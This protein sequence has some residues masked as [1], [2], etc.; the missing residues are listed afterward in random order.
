VPAG[1]DVAAESAL[2]A[3]QR[4]SMTHPRTTARSLADLVAAG[5]L[6]SSALDD[7]ALAR[8]AR[9]YAIAVT[10]GMLDLMAGTPAD[11]P[12]ARQF[13]PTADEGTTTPAELAD[14]IGDHAHAP[15][16]GIVHR[17]PDRVLLKPLHACPVYCRFCFRREQ[18]GPG[19][20]ALDDAALDAALDYVAG[21]P[22][23]WEVV[24]TGGDPF[25]LSPRRI[26]RIVAALDALPHVA[27]VRFHTRVPLVDPGRVDSALVAALRAARAA[28]YVG[29]HCNHARELTPAARG[30][31]ARLADGGLPLLSQSVLLRGVNDSVEALEAL[32]RGLVAA[33]VR[34]YYL[35][36]PD[37]ARGTSHFR[38]PIEEGQALV[39]A[40]R[41]RLSGLCQPTY[42]LDLPGG[43]GKSPIGPGYIDGTDGDGGHRIRDYRGTVHT[44]AAD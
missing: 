25:M 43:H 22:A 26:A 33:R 14:P 29:V 12:I 1:L 40:L 10:P 7:P 2:K 36:H 28:V 3:A 18:V 4:P 11:D 15:V 42:V 24:V 13:L 8:V 27:V 16:K 30:A 44:Y 6:P 23:I 39:R 20:E 31:L 41:G 32:F 35:H 37:M 19:G 9:D 5:A 17:Y 38:L 21:R 34:P